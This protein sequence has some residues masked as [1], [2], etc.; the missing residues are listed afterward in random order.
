M[1]TCDWCLQDTKGIPT[2]LAAQR[3]RSADMPEHEELCPVCA[4]LA[5]AEQ[6]VQVSIVHPLRFRRKARR[7]I[8]QV[9]A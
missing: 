1:F 8:L 5:D 7:P 4:A 3:R 2:M 9:V 6:F